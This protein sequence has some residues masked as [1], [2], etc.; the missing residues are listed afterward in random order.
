MKDL[1]DATHSVMR[2]S[3]FDVLCNSWIRLLDSFDVK[4]YKDTRNPI[5]HTHSGKHDTKTIE[6]TAEGVN[7]PF[8]ADIASLVVS[9]PLGITNDDCENLWEEVNAWML[10]IHQLIKENKKMF[11]IFH[12]D[13][14]DPQID[15]PKQARVDQR[16]TQFIVFCENPL[17]PPIYTQAASI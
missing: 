1:I 4:K 10:S 16:Q 2:P 5:K 6:K 9:T 12:G 8:I 3:H 11:M 17:T 7:F 14:K 15:R 13:S